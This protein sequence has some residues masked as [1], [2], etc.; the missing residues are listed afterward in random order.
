MVCL[1]DGKMVFRPDGAGRRYPD[2]SLGTEIAW[3]RAKGLGGKQLRIPGKRL[4]AP[5]PP[6][7]AD[8]PRAYS[9]DRRIAWLISDVWE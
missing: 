8:I 1:P 4:D 7:R 3:Y 9:A 6:L 2:G 5:A